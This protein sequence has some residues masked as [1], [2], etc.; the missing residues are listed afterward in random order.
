MATNILSLPPDVYDKISIN[1]VAKDTLSLSRTCRCL[2]RA[3]GPGNKF[4]WFSKLCLPRLS[5]NE[6]GD[7]YLTPFNTARDWYGDCVRIMNSPTQRKRCGWCLEADGP[8]ASKFTVKYFLHDREA[9]GKGGWPICLQCHQDFYEY[10][11]IFKR[12]H[13]DILNMP[14][15]AQSVKHSVDH[16]GMHKN[17]NKVVISK[18]EAKEIIER[19]VGPSETAPIG[20][21]RFAFRFKRGLKEYIDTAFQAVQIVVTE[22]HRMYKRFHFILPVSKFRQFLEE[23]LVAET[24]R[25]FKIQNTGEKADGVAIELFEICRELYGN[26]DDAEDISRRKLLV[27][28]RASFFLKSLFGGTDERPTPIENISHKKYLRGWMAEWFESSPWAKFFETHNYQSV[29][30]I[31]CARDMPHEN[32]VYE[33]K[34]GQEFPGRWIVAHLFECHPRILLEKNAPGEF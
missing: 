11:D 28:M 1:L 34:L 12:S 32:C 18:V 21:E 8:I 10:Y 31:I 16:Y 24:V 33:E 17:V 26:T 4:L 22:Y 30:C 19:H 14:K 25:P 3:F 9:R 5:A 15:L 7:H 6:D 20:S 27:G 2:R 29:Q 23:V 13:A